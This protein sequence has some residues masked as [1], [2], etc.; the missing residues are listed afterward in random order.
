MCE[1]G[2]TVFK[3]PLG[4]HLDGCNSEVKR[5]YKDLE[6]ESA[7]FLEREKKI[8]SHL[9]RHSTILHCLE[10]SD[11]ELKFPYM[12]NGNLQNFLRNDVPKP[13]HIRLK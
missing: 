11:A 8:Y 1:D 13:P 2:T 6:Q 3:T 12:T 7:E 4:F 9:G 5:E 10:I